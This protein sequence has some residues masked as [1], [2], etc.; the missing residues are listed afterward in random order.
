[1]LV[2]VLFRKIDPFEKAVALVPNS[3]PS[4]VF[5]SMVQPAMTTEMAV[6]LTEWI[7]SPPLCLMTQWTKSPLL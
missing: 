6:A 5:P 1:L 2:T 7:P 4:L 3:T